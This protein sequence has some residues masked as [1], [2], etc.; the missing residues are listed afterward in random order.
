MWDWRYN[1]KKTGKI[2]QK[3]RKELRKLS[4]VMGL[5]PM[6]LGLSVVTH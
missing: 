3:H 5:G 1:D 2:I 4:L 6:T